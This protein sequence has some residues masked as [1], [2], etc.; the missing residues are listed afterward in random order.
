MKKTKKFLSLKPETVRVI[1][2]REARLA[3]G[4]VT[5]ICS[6]TCLGTNC[7]CGPTFNDGCTYTQVRCSVNYTNCGCYGT[8]YTCETYCGC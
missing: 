5:G 8:A 6:Q 7:N 3:A 2:D 1:S 4:G